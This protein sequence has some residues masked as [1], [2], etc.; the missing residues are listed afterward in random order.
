MREG[1]RRFLR[2]FLMREGALLSYGVG[3]LGLKIHASQS[4]PNSSTPMTR[5]IFCGRE[6]AAQVGAPADDKNELKTRAKKKSWKAKAA[7]KSASGIL[8]FCTTAK[9][10]NGAH[11]ISAPAASHKA[12]TGALCP[13]KRAATKS[14]VRKIVQKPA[15]AGAPKAYRKSATNSKS[16]PATRAKI[17]NPSLA[18]GAAE[19]LAPGAPCKKRA[20]R[21]SVRPANFSPII[22]PQIGTRIS[23]TD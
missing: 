5:L 6:R 18:P 4:A 23:Y 15:L 11:N 19:R 12:E 20:P 17:K 3:G 1:R 10:H 9:T 14:G 2:N 8:R 22:S 21:E 16:V 13:A 7:L